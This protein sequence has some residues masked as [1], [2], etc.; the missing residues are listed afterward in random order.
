[1]R[2]ARPNERGDQKEQEAGSTQQEGYRN[3]GSEDAEKISPQ[4]SFISKIK[5]QKAK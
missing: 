1:V 4:T 5:M 2:K 3:C